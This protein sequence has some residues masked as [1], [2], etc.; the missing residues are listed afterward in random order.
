MGEYFGKISDY[1]PDRE[2]KHLPAW[3]TQCW[4]LED[5]LKDMNKM[6]EGKKPYPILGF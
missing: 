3:M 2:E 5:F 4:L 1:M 6:P